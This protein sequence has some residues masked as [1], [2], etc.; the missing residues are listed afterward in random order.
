VKILSISL[1]CHDAS[2]CIVED[3]K[4]IYYRPSERISRI[5][6]DSKCRTL[7]PHI[8]SLG[9]THFDEVYVS[10]IKYEEKDHI[11]ELKY[12]FHI[13]DIKCSKIIFDSK[14]HHLFH[15]YSG[16]L[17]SGFDESICFI[18][19]GGGALIT[20][21]YSNYDGNKTKLLK[22]IESV[23]LMR[24]GDPPK[25]LYKHYHAVP[26]NQSILHQSQLDRDDK[27]VEDG[28]RI[29]PSLSVGWI[30]EKYAVENGFHWSDAGKIMGL[31]QYHKKLDIYPH[32]RELILG[33]RKIQVD[34]QNHVRDMI[35]K[36]THTIKN[37]VISGGYGLNCVSNYNLLKEIPDINLHVDPNCFD[38]GLSIGQ[39]CHHTDVEPFSGVYIGGE[40]EIPEGIGR[41]S[42]IDEVI[43]LIID[44]K[45][46]AIFQG[47]SEAG[48][49]SLGNR[50]ILFD[51]R[52]K[53]ARHIVNKLKNREDYRP[54]AASVMSEHADEWFD[55]RGL[56]ESPY[57]MY[58][59]DC[60]REKVDMISGVIHAD[61]TCRIQTVTSEQNYFFY[62]IIERFYQRTGIP[63]IL[64]TSFNL[65]GQ[66]LVETP[67]QALELVV[68]IENLYFPEYNIIVTHL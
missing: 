54:F 62:K 44:Q 57:M 63:M 21:P 58:A 32:D 64:N 30:F 8:R 10:T 49:R 20:N 40:Y 61:G 2:A 26:K 50:S 31:A 6:R 14:N 18:L 25:Q 59:V 16:F 66:P 38:A 48:Q 68:N 9:H 29:S 60:K 41:E 24:K 67:E 4:L 55:M 19:D 7:I 53:N 34:T 13:H 42:S 28:V 23:Y 12:L 56:K 37:V 36:Y 27:I 52:N 33:A 3:N 39:A 65:G 46:V 5:K 47:K 1:G 45:T 17:N 22:E 51:P 35:K 15:A 11:L 43:D